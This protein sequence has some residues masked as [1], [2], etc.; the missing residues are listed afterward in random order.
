MVVS[1]QNVTQPGGST[2]LGTQDESYGFHATVLVGDVH[3]NRRISA[4][5]QLKT[6]A[7]S[8]NR[9]DDR[10]IVRKIVDV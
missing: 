10:I 2:A 8:E 3:R 5:L 9:L 1:P 4:G 6:R 7:T